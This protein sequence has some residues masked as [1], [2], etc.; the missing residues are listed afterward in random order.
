MLCFCPRTYYDYISQVS[1]ESEGEPTRV[2]LGPYARRRA[3][4]HVV[5]VQETPTTKV[6]NEES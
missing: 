2:R 3:N 1:A 5:I 6:T 4:K